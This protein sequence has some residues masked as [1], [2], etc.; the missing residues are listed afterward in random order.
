M[1]QSTL[2]NLAMLAQNGQLTAIEQLFAAPLEMLTEYADNLRRRH[3]GNTV[4]LMALLEF[5][6]YCRC[7]CLYCG[8]RRDNTGLHR[9]RLS[10]ADIMKTVSRAKSA[11]FSEIVLQSGEDAGFEDAR[12]EN[13]SMLINQLGMRLILSCGEHRYANFLQ[14]RENGAYG[15]LMRIET[16][17][18][19]LYARMHP[20]DKLR[21]RLHAVQTL[22]KLGYY[23]ATGSLIGLPGQTDADI[24]SDIE[25]F[26]NINPDFI[27]IGPLIPHPDTPL[28]NI[29]KGKLELALRTVALCRIVCP[30][31]DIP[32]TTAIEALGYRGLTKALQSGANAV[33]P[34]VTP[35]N[36]REN[37]E[38]FAGKS[39]TGSSLQ[40]LISR[41]E[42][43]GRK[44]DPVFRKQL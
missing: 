15:Y 31:A 36:A 18:P 21:D 23:T 38:I 43:I 24:I 4:K 41:L 35:A 10:E 30:D 26:R 22:Q 8:L 19:L 5:S 29:P 11:G 39:Q 1:K 34:N 2:A 14:C 44:V 7:N 16:T 27:G 33:L 17:N 9:F 12:L 3:K 28:S 37:Y 13:L 20:G 25:Y 32:A 42:A 40:N 6:N